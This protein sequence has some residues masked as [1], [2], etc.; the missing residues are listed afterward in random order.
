MVSNMAVKP[1]GYL[2]Q[3]WKVL[4]N[5]ATVIALVVL[6]VLIRKQLVSTFTTLH[7][8][9]FWAL[10]L[11]IP[12][13]LWNYHAQAKLYQGLFKIVGNHLGYRFLYE[14]SLELNFINS[15]F[16]S[17][18]V[19]GIS[20][21]GARMRSDKI[22]G[23][24]ATLVQL[25]KLMLVFMSFEIL[26]V[27]GLFFMAIK[28]HVNGLTILL[29]GSL[30]TLMIIGTLAMIFI[31]GDRR[32]I[33]VSFEFVT[34]LLN[35]LI[36][37]VRPRHPETISIERFRPTIEELHDNY[38]QME[39]HRRQLKWPLVHALEAN[40]SEILAVY[41]VYIAFGHW[42]NFGTVILAYAVAN[43]AGLVSVLPSGIG[44]Y[45]ALMTAVLAAGGIAPRISLPVTVMYRV[46]NTLLQ[47]PPGYVYY[48]RTLHH[49]GKEPEY[50][51]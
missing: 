4:L 47:L 24:R 6:V 10:L 8:V 50:V 25:M 7:K 27:F 38:K 46:L 37:V 15:V 51:T 31:I 39:T 44:V 35:R 11:L 33:N 48:H 41:V 21:F 22:S 5:I 12:I 17:G 18:G 49:T 1:T 16:P 13:E 30:T 26:L 42:V 20:Y 34:K 43:F 29:G 19:S 45:E 14:T 9:D 40:F 32:R 23:G 2:K 28:G 36:Q 3:H